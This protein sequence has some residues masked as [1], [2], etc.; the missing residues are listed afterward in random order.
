MS[1]LRWIGWLLL[2]APAWAQTQIV[3]TLRY[4]FIDPATNSNLANCI[5]YIT[6]VTPSSDSNN[7]YVPSTLTYVV[8]NGVVNLTLQ[9]NDA[10]TPAG[11]SYSVQYQCAKDQ[12]PPPEIWVV[13]SGGPFPIRAVRAAV[14]PSPALMFSPAQLTNGGATPGQYLQWNGQS[15][16]GEA[17]AAGGD[18][19]GSLAGATVVAV[20][21][22]AISSTAPSDGQ[23]MR[24]NAAAAQWE[25][26]K[27]RYT[28]SL[29]GATSVTIPGSTHQLGTQDI[30]VTCFD[31]S[32]TPQPVEPDR[33]IVD[34]GTFDVT[35]NFSMPQTGRCVLR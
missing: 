27:I 14:V 1:S 33:W 25:P 28:V 11:T 34:A 3:D 17:P 6:D 19:A 26:I 13:P 21:G 32:S 10:A 22:E 9:P 16:I 7:T 8:V 5:L 24:W 23:V 12:T 30:T 4:R 20:Q 15:W 29:T 18:L 2:T 35:I 31:N